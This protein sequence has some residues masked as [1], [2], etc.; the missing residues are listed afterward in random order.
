M[1]CSV[2]EKVTDVLSTPWER[3]SYTKTMTTLHSLRA[4]PECKNKGSVDCWES[5]SKALEEQFQLPR[6]PLLLDGFR[7]VRSKEPNP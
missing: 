6:A 3:V 2:N 1:S 5:Q 7:L 4:S